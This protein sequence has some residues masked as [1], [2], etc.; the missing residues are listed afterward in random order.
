VVKL[1][2]PL[3]STRSSLVAEIPR[4]QLLRLAFIRQLALCLTLVDKLLMPLVSTRSSQVME[5]PRMQILRL[6]MIRQLNLCLTIGSF[7]GAALVVR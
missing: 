2:M 1:L 3:V 7:F 5:I 6:A 4:M